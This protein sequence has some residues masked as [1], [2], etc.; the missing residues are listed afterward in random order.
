MNMDDGLV[1]LL[2]SREWC[3]HPPDSTVRVDP[4]RA[5]RM[6]KDGLEKVAPAEAPKKTGKKKGGG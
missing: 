3:G 5:K 1:A 2:L 4:A 6:R